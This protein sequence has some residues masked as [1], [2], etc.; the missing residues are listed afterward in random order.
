[1]P[2]WLNV[3]NLFTLLR[4][5]L[6]PFIIQAIFAAQHLRALGLFAAAAL[7]DAL[8]GVLARRF[9][10][11]TSAGAYFD[12]IADKCLLSGVFL[13][14]AMSG[15]MPWWLVAIVFARDI[16]I[17]LG[18][19]LFLMLTSVRRF[20]PSVWGKVSTFVQI[21]TVVLW[22]VRNAFPNLVWEAVADAML[23]AAAAFTLW[24]GIDYT[25]RGIQFAKGN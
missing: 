24:S 19:C 25:R 23:G 3:P 22:M 5:V 8:D 14:L 6:I 17:L 2:P 1:M 7:T 20:P 12:P 11:I 13:A 21:V 18:A 4:L 15:L 10:S 9:G 16:Y